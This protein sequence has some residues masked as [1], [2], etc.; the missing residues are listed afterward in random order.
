MKNTISLK[1]N[2]DFRRLYTRGKHAGG[3]FITVYMLPGRGTVSRLGLTVSKSVGK[4]HTR[5]RVKRLI[6]EAYRLTEAELGTGY[7]FVIAARASAAEA[8]F[9]QIDKDMRRIFVR[10]GILK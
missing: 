10:L 7:D 1:L 6:R 9:W 3:R 2:R 8:D 4:A 5:N